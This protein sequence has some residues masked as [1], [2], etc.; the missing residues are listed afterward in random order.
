MRA[1]LAVLVGVGLWGCDDGGADGGAER[2]ETDAERRLGGEDGGAS[3]GG[4]DRDGGAPDPSDAAVQD[5][6]IIPDGRPAEGVESCA[7][8]CD[9]FAG[10]EQLTERYRDEAG[11]LAACERSVRDGTA[12]PWFQCLNQVPGCEALGVCEAPPPAPLSCAEVCAEVAACGVEGPFVDCAAECEALSPAARGAVGACADRLL[13]GACDSAQFRTCLA[14][15]VFPDCDLQCQRG[16]TC[17]VV[18]AP[19]CLSACLDAA[20]HGDP[21]QRRR[22]AQRAACVNAARDD[23]FVVNQCLVPDA[24]VGLGHTC[25]ES[26]AGLAACGLAQPGC[27]AEC[28]DQRRADPEGQQFLID[29]VVEF[30]AVGGQCFP[31]GF[32]NCLALDPPRRDPP[33]V[34]LCEAQDLCGLGD[35]PRAACEQACGGAQL[36]PA[37]AAAWRALLPCGRAES[38]AAAE[39]CL[40]EEHPQVQCAAFCDGL[41]ACELA[42]A[43]CAARCEAEFGSIRNE[44]ARVCVAETACDDIPACLP[45]PPPLA[46]D[47]HCARLAACD[48]MALAGHADAAACRRACDAADL[49]DP[50]T[51]ERLMAC[52]TTAPACASMNPLE[53]GHFVGSCLFD[54]GVAGVVGQSCLRFCRARAECAGDAAGLAACAQAC[55][56]GYGGEDALRY[57]AAAECLAA[58]DPA[59]ACDALVACVPDEVV[60]D[61]D[62]VCGPVEACGIDPADCRAA[63]EGGPDVEQA[64]CVVAA[65]SR[66][67]GCAAIAACVG[68]EA[69]APSPACATT[70]DAQLRCDPSLDAF[71]CRLACTPAPDGLAIQAACAQATPCRALPACLELP[72]EPAPACVAACETAAACDEAFDV[73]ACAA[74]CTGRAASPRAPADYLAAVGTCMQAVVD[75][76]CVRPA[77]DCLRVPTDCHIACQALADCNVG[78]PLGP[79]DQCAAFLCPNGPPEPLFERTV[80]CALA[81][82]DGGLCDDDAYLQC[83]LGIVLP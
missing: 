21:L 83:T 74:L 33:C 35:Q 41:A 14:Q 72:P 79:P 2:Q 9:R 13:G 50:A 16:A 47:A 38:C 67:A 69:P 19:E 57:A 80:T 28:E 6:R 49:Q 43:G 73:A 29:C 22:V 48:L 70:C 59:P 39:A 4:R 44:A 76:A 58:L 81:T 60:V 26:C 20:L 68:F 34:G 55:T 27:E 71:R 45:P 75:D 61:C 64:G 3:D 8:V 46:C 10:C 36:D 1:L 78:I 25:A 65:A 82:L 40:A 51:A 63:C 15:R 32:Q 12:A 30:I 56:A 17:N 53:A 42:D 18:R 37:A 23:C 24:S 31:E 77:L 7:D 52:T 5:A 66:G 62:A 11:C 54:A